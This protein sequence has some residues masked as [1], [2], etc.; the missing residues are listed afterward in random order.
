LILTGYV[1]RPSNVD[2]HSLKYFTLLPAGFPSAIQLFGG[3]AV[4]GETLSTILPDPR[5]N[6]FTF[7]LDSVTLYVTVIVES[8][9]S[10]QEG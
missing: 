5:L 7:H 3:F 9:S 1:E 8:D 10:I 6:P 2:G 4:V